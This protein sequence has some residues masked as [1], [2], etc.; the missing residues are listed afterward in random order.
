MRKAGG[1][2]NLGGTALP[3]GCLS[4]VLLGWGYFTGMGLVFWLSLAPCSDKG[5]FLLAHSWLSQ[6]GF[7][8]ETFWEVGR[9]YRLAF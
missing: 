3:R 4:Q 7:Q 9:T 1:E 2:G 6:S 8:Q 5:S